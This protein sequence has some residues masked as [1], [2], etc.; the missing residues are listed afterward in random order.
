MKA[1]V[2]IAGV[3]II[4]ADMWLI[5]NPER[6]STPKT[7]PPTKPLNIPL[8]TCMIVHHPAGQRGANQ[9]G[10]KIKLDVD[11]FVKYD[12]IAPLDNKAEQLVI[13][14]DSP[15]VDRSNYI[16]KVA[17]VSSNPCPAA[18][19]QA[20]T[21]WKKVGQHILAKDKKEYT[22]QTVLDYSNFLN[23]EKS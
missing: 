18:Y 11:W 4:W 12:I 20:G 8:R 9:T 5:S 13:M 19:L 21:L 3:L 15:Q 2:I 10:F 6:K 17:R 1:I 22:G 7:I 23:N 14:S 16:Y